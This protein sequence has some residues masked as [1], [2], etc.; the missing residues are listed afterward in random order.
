MLAVKLLIKILAKD[1]LRLD[2]VI[3]TNRTVYTKLF[4]DQSSNFLTFKVFYR[5]LLRPE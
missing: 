3:G 4:R 5:L 2:F 1:K